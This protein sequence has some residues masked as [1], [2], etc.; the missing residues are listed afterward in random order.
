M[1]A[2][3]LRRAV[4]MCRSTQ[5]AEMLSCPPMNH[6]ACGGFQSS[7]VVHGLYQRSSFACASQ[8][9]SG[10]CAAASY[11]FWSE[12]CAPLRNESGGEKERCSWRSASISDIRGR[13][14]R[15]G[16]RGRKG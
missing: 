2:A 8:N 14:K 4:L 3:L 5:F 9:A 1:S 11:T 16:G 15:E 6:F 7:T 10:F 12:T 13:G